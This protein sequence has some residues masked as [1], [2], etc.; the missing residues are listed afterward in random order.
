MLGWF[1]PRRRRG[2]EVLDNPEVPDAVRTRAMADVARSNRLFGGTRAVVTTVAALRAQLPPNAIILDVGTGTGDIA[3]A[4]R[5]QFPGFRCFGL[6]M[7]DSL[8]RVARNDLDALL[9]GDARRLPLR[10]RSVDLVICSQVLHH[11]ETADAEQL[12]AEL[13]RVSRGWVL[14]SDLRRSWVAAG[15]FLVAATALRFHPITRGDGI[16]SVLRGFTA[17]DLGEHVARATGISPVVR[18]KA[19]WRLVATWRARS[20][21]R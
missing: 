17:R 21:E 2:V 6:D 13:D 5:R 8:L 4:L 20:T 9:A 3:A 19:L 11:F 16:T 15:G 18:R 10:D 14:I 7:S 1:T 12:I